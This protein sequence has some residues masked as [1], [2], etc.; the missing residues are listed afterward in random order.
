MKFKVIFALISI[1][2]STSLLAVELDDSF[3][4]YNNDEKNKA[5]PLVKRALE[6]QAKRPAKGGELNVLI[7][8]KTQERLAKS[9]DS[10]IPESI[11][12]TTRE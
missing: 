12:V 9:F 10:Q 3:G 4:F 7:Y 6:S 5:T 8:L 1:Y 11:S 2:A